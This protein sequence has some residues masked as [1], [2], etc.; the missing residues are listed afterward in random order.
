LQR[1]RAGNTTWPAAWGRGLW[2]NPSVRPIDTTK[3][4]RVA[5][6]KRIDLIQEAH[7]ETQNAKPN[8]LTGAQMLSQKGTPVGVLRAGHVVALR[9]M[10]FDHQTHFFEPP[11]CRLDINVLFLRNLIRILPREEDARHPCD[12]AR[13]P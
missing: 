12:V 10:I 13:D 7:L 9:E 6:S 11:V 3:H 2:Q 5:R 1:A 8:D 4:K